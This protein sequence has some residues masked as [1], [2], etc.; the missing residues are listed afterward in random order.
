MVGILIYK[1]GNWNRR[2]ANVVG[3]ARQHK[4][5]ST[6]LSTV[7]KHD[8]NLMVLIADL[9]TSRHCIN[10]FQK[11]KIDFC[12]SLL[13]SLTFCLPSPFLFPSHSLKICSF[14]CSHILFSL[15]LSHLLSFWLPL[16]LVSCLFFT[17]CFHWKILKYTFFS[18][19]QL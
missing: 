16:H 17:V 10:C 14:S 9:K 11:C 1:S 3:Q 8:T 4:F 13:L 2:T 5:K 18:F 12:L 19:T 7:L 15:S 6:T